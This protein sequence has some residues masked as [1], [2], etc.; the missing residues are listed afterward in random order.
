MKERRVESYRLASSAT[1]DVVNQELPTC[2]V[3]TTNGVFTK[4]SWRTGSRFE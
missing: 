3:P 4:R 2:F 1:V